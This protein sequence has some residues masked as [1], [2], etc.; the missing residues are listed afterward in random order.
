VDSLRDAQRTPL[1][2]N[3]P[4][5]KLRAGDNFVK[6]RGWSKV[7]KHSGFSKEDYYFV[8]SS[9]KY[10]DLLGAWD[11]GKNRY[12]AYCGDFSLLFDWDVTLE[13]ATALK[14]IRASGCPAV[15]AKGYASLK[16]AIRAK[17]PGSIRTE[18]EI[19]LSPPHFEGEG[20]QARVVFEGLEFDQHYSNT[21]FQYRLEIGNE[22]YQEMRKFLIVG[23]RYLDKSEVDPKPSSGRNAP[24]FLP[25]SPEALRARQAAYAE[26]QK[27]FKLVRP[28]L[29]PIRVPPLTAK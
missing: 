5:L 26:S 18:E 4:F 2:D 28:F 13:N 10:Y 27:F 24:I 6:G 19:K 23:P 1:F 17:F 3:L 16:A 14:N 7:P 15:S 11:E 22:I 21:V 8:F 25:S 20:R 12:L 9:G 29:L